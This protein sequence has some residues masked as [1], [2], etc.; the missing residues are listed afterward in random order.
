M[1]V[2]RT[3]GAGEQQGSCYATKGT[4]SPVYPMG[5]K[6]G[7]EGEPTYYIYTYPRN[8][9]TKECQVTV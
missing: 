3:E 9:S 8:F 5:I 4:P 1:S 6:V 7:G 2:L